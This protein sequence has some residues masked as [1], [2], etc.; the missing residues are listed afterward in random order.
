[1]QDPALLTIGDKVMTADDTGAFVIGG[2]TIT[3]GG[4]VVTMSGTIYSLVP[5]RTAI[6]VNGV[7]Q[8]ARP[9]LPP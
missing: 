2:M 4:Y 5:S 7:T 9:S 6:V 3:P 1:M 8:T